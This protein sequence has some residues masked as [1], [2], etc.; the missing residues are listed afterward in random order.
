MT[1]KAI[2]G[3]TKLAIDGGEPTH[4]GTWPAWP[5]P[6]DDRQR[7]LLGQVL[8]GGAWGSN[9]GP[10]CEQFAHEFAEAHGVGHGVVLANGTIALF[11][12]LQAAG[13]GAGDEVIIPSYTFVACAT[14]V[15]LLGATPVIAEVDSDHLHLSAATIEDALSERTRAVMV[16]HLAGSPAPMD[17]INELALRHG[18]VV[19]EDAAQ[20]HGARYRGRPVGSLGTVATFS[21]QSSKAMTAGEGGLIT[22]HDSAIAD[23]AWSICNV[24]RERNGAWYGHTSIGWN[25]RMTEFQAALLIPWLDRL[26]GEIAQ[27]E[28]FVEALLDELVG[29]DG[30]VSVVADPEGT[31][32]NSRHLLML[33]LADTREREWIAAALEA[34]GVP[35]DLGYPHLGSI[36]A[37]AARSRVVGDPERGFGELLWLRQPLL[38]SGAEG[39]AVVAGALRRVLAD[40]RSARTLAGL[41]R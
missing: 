29:L 22:T 38:M 20:A 30:A 35:V 25:L 33:R 14:S 17:E 39:A 24:G 27:R 1:T 4:D 8:D 32:R 40:P 23:R 19:V 31:T 15:L 28:S 13:V 26:D 12:A 36:D 21:F 3:A 11:V 10:L 5:P 9:T 7:A 6:A 16:V 2:G 34:E 18:L 41:S 37:V